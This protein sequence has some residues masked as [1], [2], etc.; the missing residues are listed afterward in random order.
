MIYK[1][2]EKICIIPARLESSRF[3]NKILT[4]INGKKMFVAVYEIAVKS[5][6]FDQVYVATHNSEVLRL[7]DSLGI[8]SIET[9]AD[10]ICGS[11]RVFE[12]AKKIKSNWDVVVN[13]Q[14]DQP[15]LPEHYLTAVIQGFKTNPISTIAYVDNSDT[16]EHTVKVI[17]DKNNNGVYFSRYPIPFQVNK[18]VTAKYC[19]LG[20]Y[21][22][23]HDFVKNYTGDFQSNLALSESLEQL[24][25]IYNGFRIDV[26]LVDGA[27]P[28]INTQ[29]DIIKAMALGLISK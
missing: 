25:F 9:K 8:P 28:E 29:E 27:V 21:A 17:L 12:A 3:P 26:K 15:F 5:G 18:E 23:K 16:N 10:H 1:M 13:L 20:L 22:Y 11:S 24:D 14:A 7:C 19:H 4:D 6:V 2:G